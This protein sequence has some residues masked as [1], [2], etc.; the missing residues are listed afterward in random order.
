MRRSLPN[1]VALLIVMVVCR[2]A[3]ASPESNEPTVRHTD[4]DVRT[5]AH[6][7][8]AGF[9]RIESISVAYRSET[10]DWRYSGV[11]NEVLRVHTIARGDQFLETRTVERSTIPSRHPLHQERPELYFD[12]RVFSKYW[13]NNRILHQ[14]MPEPGQPLDRQQDYLDS[15]A[16][17]PFSRSRFPPPRDTYVLPDTLLNNDYAV[18]PELTSVGKDA[19]V[20]VTWRPS[21]QPGY[22]DKMWMNPACGWALRR[23]EIRAADNPNHQESKMVIQLEDPREVLPGLW[24]PWH[25]TIKQVRRSQSRDGSSDADFVPIV[26]TDIHVERLELNVPVPAS[27]FRPTLQPGTIIEDQRTETKR[28]LPGGEAVLDDVILRAIEHFGWNQN[29]LHEWFSG[30]NSSPYILLGCAGGLVGA[31]GLYLKMRFGHRAAI[32]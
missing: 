28:V 30:N 22:E 23:R 27:A 11:R 1:P 2:C 8:A 24:L 7:I 19:C 29:E 14:L 13:K 32:S 21:S 9:D 20:V 18:E 15:I 6:A 10:H 3:H 5:I 25:V 17:R 4:A 31:V 26:A 16:Y 12:G